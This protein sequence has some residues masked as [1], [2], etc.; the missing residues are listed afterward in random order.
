MTKKAFNP[1]VPEDLNRPYNVT[2]TEGEIGTILHHLEIVSSKYGTS[3]EIE[4]IFEELE[5][6]VDNYYDA[7]GVEKCIADGTDYSECV[8]ALV[9]RMEKLETAKRVAG[10]EET[11]RF[12]SALEDNNPYKNIPDRY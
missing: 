9:D 10:V 3:D 11:N 2:L 7:K 4:R 6:A 8:D 5:G 12:L 1:S